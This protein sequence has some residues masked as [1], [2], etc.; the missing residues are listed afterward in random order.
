MCDCIIGSY[1]FENA[2]SSTEIVNRE[3]YRHMLNTF[4][5][6]V[7]IHRRNRYELWFQQDVATCHTDNE[8]VDVL[9]RMFGNNAISLRAALTLPPSSPNQN[10]PDYY[11]WKYWKERVC[12]NRPNNMVDSKDNIIRSVMNNALV[13]ARSCIAV[14]GQHL[15]DIIFRG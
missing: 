1:F 13:R 10:A 14:E 11:L 6:P 15:R 4:L 5:R 9:Q 3:R 7:V 8:T 2:E 12:I